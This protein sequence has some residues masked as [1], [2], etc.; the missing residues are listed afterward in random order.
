MVNCDQGL[1]YPRDWKAQDPYLVNKCNQDVI[2]LNV[3]GLEMNY[4]LRC[5]VCATWMCSV[6]SVSLLSDKD[7]ISDQ[8]SS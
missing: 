3:V 4:V 8:N 1:S 5:E 7:Q 2:A 6:Q